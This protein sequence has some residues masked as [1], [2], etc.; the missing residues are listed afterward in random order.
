MWNPVQ[1]NGSISTTS[2]ST[3]TIADGTATVWSNPIIYKLTSNT[4]FHVVYYYSESA[5]QT[6]TISGTYN[7]KDT[8]TLTSNFEESVGFT[9]GGTAFD[10]MKVE[11]GQVSN[12]LTY[13]YSTPPGEFPYVS[14]YTANTSGGSGGYTN[15]N[16]KTVN[17]GTTAQ[18]VSVAFKEWIE[19]NSNLGTGYTVTMNVSGVSG[20]TF[21]VKKNSQASDTN[22]D[23]ILGYGDTKT[24][25]IYSL[26]DTISIVPAAGKKYSGLL[27]Y[28]L[29]SDNIRVLTNYNTLNGGGQF[30]LDTL[31]NVTLT[32]VGTIN[33]P[34][35]PV[36]LSFK[37]TDYNNVGTMNIS[38]STDNVTWTTPSSE[39]VDVL[40]EPEGQIAYVYFKYEW[41]TPSS[42]NINML[43]NVDDGYPDFANPT[44]SQWK[45]NNAA[46][47]VQI[48]PIVKD[49]TTVIV[50]VEKA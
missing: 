43:I 30:Q 39:I 46:G 49:E 13:K 37:S 28:L 9:S 14:A 34:H 29:D 44:L 20:D 18:T 42:N 11:I 26:S 27:N 16:Y 35:T 4:N 3:N 36:W 6:T 2:P 22:Y 48:V 41:A 19:S 40:L 24:L 17:F 45:A 50:D 15:D 12:S 47:V 32:V 10:G 33:P 31:A 1:T 23:F 5:P 21:Y 7:L 8:L 38:Y 25:T